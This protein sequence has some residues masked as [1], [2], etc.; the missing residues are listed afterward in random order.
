MYYKYFIKNSSKYYKFK[1]IRYLKFKQH[2][3]ILL[4]IIFEK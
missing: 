3:T 4:I 2:L 1:Y